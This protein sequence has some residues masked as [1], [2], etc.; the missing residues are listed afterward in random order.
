MVRS[1]GKLGRS[2]LFASAL[3]LLLSCPSFAAP[4]LFPDPALTAGNS[5]FISA[6]ADLNADGHADVIVANTYY[7]GGISVFLGTG[8]GGFMPESRI[9]VGSAPFW[10]DIGDLN[11]DG[12]PDIAAANYGGDVSILIGQGDGTFTMATSVGPVGLATCL[13]I[14]DFDEDTRSDLAVLDNN[15]GIVR[16]FRGNGDG[17]FGFLS[18][19]AVP[20]GGYGMTQADFD[21]DGHSDLAVTNYASMTFA[22]L[23]GTGTGSF[24]TL[25][26]FPAGNDPEFI[27]SDDFNGD[28]RPDLV[29][30]NSATDSVD[31]RLGHGNGRF[32]APTTVY[33]GVGRRPYNLVT[34][35]FNED[36]RPDI[37]TLNSGQ[38]G[39]VTIAGD[40]SVLLGDGSGG[41]G[42]A[43]HMAGFY[44]SSPFAIVAADI[45]EDGHVDVAVNDSGSPSRLY[46]YFGDGAGNL[47]SRRRTVP[48]GQESAQPAVGDINDDGVPDLLVP[49][50]GAPLASVDRVALFLATPGGTY[51]PAGEIPVAHP[52]SVFVEDLDGDGHNDLL[53]C[54]TPTSGGST[55]EIRAYLGDGNGGFS[56]LAAVAS[57][58]GPAIVADFD[59]DGKTDIARTFGSLSLPNDPGFVRVHRGLGGGFFSA[60]VDHTVAP[61]P[62]GLTTGDFNGD[63]I[64]DIAV[65]A[66]W[67]DWSTL[68]GD[69]SVLLGN[70]DA[71][72]QPFLSFGSA[73]G[74]SFIATGEFTGDGIPDL[75]VSY[76]DYI[77][78]S[79]IPG[80]AQIFVGDGQG[81]FAP[82]ISLATTS[83]GFGIIAADLD[84][85]GNDDIALATQPP[86]T[87]FAGPAV[88]VARGKGDGTFQPEELFYQHQDSPFLTSADVNRDGRPDLVVGGQT[89]VEV[90]P[91]QGAQSGAPLKAVAAAMTPAECTSPAGTL[92]TLDGTG[93]N[94]PGYPAGT[95]DGIVAFDWYEDFGGSTQSNIGSGPMLDA[96]LPI[97]SHTI[98]LRV[99]DRSGASDTDTVGVE[100]VDTTPPLLD[101]VVEPSML[102]PPNHRM[103][104]VEVAGRAAD[105][106]DPSPTLAYLRVARSEPDDAPG[107][108][109][110]HTS[111]DVQ[112]VSVNGLDVSLMLRAERDANGPGRTY[113]VVYLAMDDAGNSA[114]VGAVILVPHDL[115]GN[116]EPV[117]L[118]VTR[119]AAAGTSG[120][121]LGW[122]APSDAISYDILRGRVGGI[123]GVGSYTTLADTVCVGR[124]VPVT[125]LSGGMMEENPALG[126]AFFYVVEY[127]DGRYSGYGTA[128]SGGEIVVASGDWCR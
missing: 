99:T 113:T 68:T 119:P 34:G 76:D 109:D 37:V 33:V 8:G 106:C 54:T 74:A 66:V 6:S 116:T 11:A 115:G 104:L 86:Y 117:F 77:N 83:R 71:T 100:V 28:G 84:S 17:T 126:A 26:P 120:T 58:N 69:V 57:G 108:S 105:A 88:L 107:G 103:V 31:V 32:A 65:A 121:V 4:P 62:S 27:A 39:Q 102:W 122:T 7:P 46:V 91:N 12:A 1:S 92:V 49:L 97:G 64:P 67:G 15:S 18:M 22:V 75:A 35:D 128:S 47:G 23:L 81:H 55:P 38:Y 87:T 114:E 2:L 89:L 101:P 73:G 25:G 3:R 19:T 45:D 112:V 124:A 63:G 93:S 14:A 21:R 9:A 123:V 48:T 110:G 42:A 52:V 41:F 30:A 94:G 125:S 20:G 90:L 56:F 40:I 10:L 127:Y 118:D 36:G 13:V 70:G 78:R 44:L 16:I 82:G 72:F 59:R 24:S 95:L 98:T 53:V 50:A 61:A 60:G 79:P 29:I 96:S 80:A 51:T 85:D 5:P 43:Q 111:D